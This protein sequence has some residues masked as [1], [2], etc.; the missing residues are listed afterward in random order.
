MSIILYTAPNCLRCSIVK[1]FLTEQG[2]RYTTVDFKAEAPVFNSFYRAQ[3]SSIYRNAEGVEFPIYFDGN[4]VRQGA[5][6]IIAHVLGQGALDLA[7]TPS[8][9]LHGWISGLNVSLCPSEQA[10]NF[11]Q[12]VRRLKTGGLKVCVT[13][14][15][16]QPELLKQILPDLDRCELKVVGDAEVYLALYGE[17]L[18]VPDLSQSIALVTS[19]KDQQIFY[20][21]CA[22]PRGEAKGWATVDEA[23]AA[24][25]MI[26]EASYKQ[27]P[28][29]VGLPDPELAKLVNLEPLPESALFKYRTALREYLF[30]ADILK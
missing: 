26:A 8:K 24:A 23:K 27:L 30:K 15:G 12:V 18:T 7:V 9:L 19:L 5:G 29:Y 16:R 4:V 1:A 17:A 28:C 6:I 13:T 21:I 2:L 14:D 25:K 22:L 11:V 10:D 20:S 3:R